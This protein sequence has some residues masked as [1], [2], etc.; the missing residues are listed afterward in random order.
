MRGRRRI[1]SPQSCVGDRHEM[2]GTRGVAPLLTGYHL[3]A[4]QSNIYRHHPFTYSS[5]KTNLVEISPRILL[6][7]KL[8]PQRF[9]LSICL[10]CRFG[11]RMVIPLS[12]GFGNISVKGRRWKLASQISPTRALL[13]GPFSLQTWEYTPVGRFLWMQVGSTE[14]IPIPYM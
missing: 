14:I 1:N 9:F 13:A 6:I 10:S 4:S 5:I 2:D 8:K 12:L 7:P 11:S 3:S